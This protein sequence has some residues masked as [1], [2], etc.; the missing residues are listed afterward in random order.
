MAC[1]DKVSHLQF[2]RYSYYSICGFFSLAVL[3][4]RTHQSRYANCSAW[5][6]SAYSQGLT[7]AEA[8]WANQKYHTHGAP[9]LSMVEEVK[10]SLHG[11]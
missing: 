9:P 6:L 3:H 7:G 10:W 11:K 1:L 2:I 8:V 4:L 5:F